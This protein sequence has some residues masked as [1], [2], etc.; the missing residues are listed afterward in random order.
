M[1]GPSGYSAQQPDPTLGSG[2][3]EALEPHPNGT[4]AILAGLLGL[5]LAALAG[6]VPINFFIHIESGFSIGD[7]PGIV[8]VYLGMFLGAALFL[9]IGALAALFRA[10]AGAVMLLVGSLLATASILFEP[11]ITLHNDYALYFKVVF[12]LE[13]L[14]Q[15]VRVA[16][17]VLAPLVLILAA[18]PPTFA[19]L[20][21]RTPA[22][23]PYDPNRAYPRQSW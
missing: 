5:V 14:E 23:R 6:Y 11:M 12:T 4:T 21:Y 3:A 15:I 20:R 19:Y 8:L 2:H 16:T 1:A 10:V 9:L 17:L 22:P 7:L 13:G 18:L